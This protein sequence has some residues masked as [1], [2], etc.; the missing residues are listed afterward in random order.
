MITFHEGRAALIEI[1]AA[2]HENDQEADD[3]TAA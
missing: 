2:D 1:T 3:G